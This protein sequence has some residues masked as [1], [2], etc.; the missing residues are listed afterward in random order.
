[1]GSCGGC[2]NDIRN[3]QTARSEGLQDQGSAQKR[4]NLTKVAGV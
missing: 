2:E 3:Y 4:K 1:M